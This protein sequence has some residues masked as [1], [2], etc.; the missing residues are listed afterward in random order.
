MNVEHQDY[1]EQAELTKY[2]WLGYRHLLTADEQLADVAFG[3]EQKF[4]AHRLFVTEP[5]P[6][7]EL[8]RRRKRYENNAYVQQA[9]RLGYE[10]FQAKVRDRIVQEMPESFF[11][12]RCPACQRIVATPRAKQCL[13]CGK[14]WHRAE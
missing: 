10:G 1:D 2:V 7:P 6:D 5:E 9:L 12:N 13:W 8:L 4:G 14:D 3:V 11:V